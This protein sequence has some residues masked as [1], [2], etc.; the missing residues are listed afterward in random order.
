LLTVLKGKRVLVLRELKE[1]QGKNSRGLQECCVAEDSMADILCTWAKPTSFTAV[2]DWF[3]RNL[4][5]TTEWKVC[6]AQSVVDHIDPELERPASSSTPEQQQQQQGEQQDHARHD[7]SSVASAVL[8]PAAL[9][10][11]GSASSS[12]ALPAAT[13]GF[14][15]AS[16]EPTGTG[17]FAL[18]YLAQRTGSSMSK[19]QYRFETG[20][21]AKDV[22][23]RYDQWSDIQASRRWDG[24]VVMVRSF[25]SVENAQ[26]LREILILEGCKHP[27]IA[28]IID[29]CAAPDITR[30]VY[31][32]SPTTVLLRSMMNGSKW[33]ASQKAF[34]LQQALQ[35]IMFVHQQKI[36]HQNLSPDAIFLKYSVGFAPVGVQIA[37]F[38]GS[39]AA[40]HM[41]LDPIGDIEFRSPELLLG[42]LE[43]P[44]QC[45]VWSIAAIFGHLVVGCPMWENSKDLATQ[46]A[47]VVKLLGPI[48]C[49]DCAGLIGL[50]R[51]KSAYAVDMEPTDW[52]KA[53]S[54][55]GGELAGDL[56]T[57]MLIFSPAR[58]RSVW[59]HAVD[60]HC[61][62]QGDYQLF[63]GPVC[64]HTLLG[65]CLLVCAP[66]HCQRESMS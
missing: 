34:I 32:W 40:G 25:K 23:T 45:D 1:K 13:A 14:G 22:P 66:M 9:A 4:K 59:S 65:F 16:A 53:V 60:A 57:D 52:K 41:K 44:R 42:I 19:P 47:K 39:V 35:G 6:I 11:A 10:V 21:T 26:P 64:L 30:L 17:W 20:Y 37:D 36:V 2:Y 31:S 58:H 38:C 54:Q 15:S 49:L 18:L 28:E 29:V 3:N 5:A 48:S 63:S 61:C 62:A 43:A 51:W 46:M 33:S 12:A 7:M 8:A 24:S 56:L 55:G 50:P 27:N